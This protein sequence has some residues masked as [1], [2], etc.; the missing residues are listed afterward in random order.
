MH[1]YFLYES[2]YALHTF[3]VTPNLQFHISDPSGKIVQNVNYS[4][5]SQNSDLS[6][7][8]NPTHQH[9]SSGMLS[10]QNRAPDI[11][12]LKFHANR[13]NS[14]YLEKCDFQRKLIF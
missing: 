12:L 11:K 5:V 7:K 3:T 2:N 6:S 9:E 14:A 10:F 13:N 8:L 4:L 1:S